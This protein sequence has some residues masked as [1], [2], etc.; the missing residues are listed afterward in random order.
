[1][2]IATIKLLPPLF[3]PGG[4]GGVDMVEIGTVLLTSGS[5][6]RI[7][8]AAVL[9]CAMAESFAAWVREV[10]GRIA[11][12]GAPL[13]GVQ[14]LDSYECRTRDRI[15]GAKLSE[16][17]KGDAI[18]VGAF[19]LTDGRRIKL[20]DT[21]VPEQLR[22][23]LRNTACHSFTTVLG[24]GADKY[25]N[26]HIHLDNLVRK[27]G[28][29]ICQWDVRARPAPSP[30]IAQAQ[31][32]SPA[33]PEVGVSNSR[34]S[35]TVT[36]GPWA[37]ATT[38]KAG[39]FVNCTM[40]RSVNDLGISFLR[41]QNGLQLLL[42]SPKWKLDRGKA[43]SVRLVAGSRSVKSKAIAETRSVT[44]ALAD[45]R[46]NSKLRSTNMLEVHGKGATLHVPLDE[47]ARAFERLEA[48]FNNQEA[49]ETNPF[50]RRKAPQ[51]NPFKMRRR[52]R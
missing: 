6:V 18:D 3:G 27:H 43:Y 12:L 34:D 36:V 10:S 11:M 28:Y 20:T 48:C 42:D 37:I 7:E 50:V 44:I 46:L 22:E 30:Q 49:L 4:C 52:E 5:R 1:M 31:V 45:S 29:R 23:Q 33:T 32:Q 14:N 8:P 16:H 24:P 2:A 38:Y 41:T 17:A 15:S 9:R 47:S 19:V 26:H 35:Q 40:S 39:Q 21:S 51:K 13:R 25:H